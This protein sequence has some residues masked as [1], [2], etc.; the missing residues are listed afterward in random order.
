MALMISMAEIN[1]YG[2]KKEAN[3]LRSSI[4]VIVV[5]AIVSRMPLLPKKL[6]ISD[7]NGKVDICII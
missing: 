3:D 7:V 2:K 5:F 4:S 6:N 1:K